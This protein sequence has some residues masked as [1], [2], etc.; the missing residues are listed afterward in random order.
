MDTHP[1]ILDR[2]NRLR[3]LS[4]EGPLASSEAAGLAGLD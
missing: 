4:G 2:I 3:E 1:S